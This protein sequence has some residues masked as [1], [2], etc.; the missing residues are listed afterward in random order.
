MQGSSWRRRTP[1][2][3]T[4]VQNAVIPTCPMAPSTYLWSETAR[5]HDAVSRIEL[6]E[7]KSLS[8]QSTRIHVG[9][10][11]N[12]RKWAAATRALVILRRCPTSRLCCIFFG[13]LSNRRWTASST[14][15]CSKRLI[16]RFLSLAARFHRTDLTGRF[17]LLLFFVGYRSFDRTLPGEEK[18]SR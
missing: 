9:N 14:C 4:S 15:S 2:P 11:S 12:R 17:E 3:Q 18:V 1:S 8:H 16:R 7:H 5:G 13:F 6:A 10:P